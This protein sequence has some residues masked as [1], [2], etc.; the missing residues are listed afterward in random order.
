MEINT[1]RSNKGESFGKLQTRLRV[2][3]SAKAGRNLLKRNRRVD[4]HELRKLTARI[5][6]HDK[7][8]AILEFGK[9]PTFGWA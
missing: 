1:Y 4:L 3:A 6:R 9:Q 7:K 8:I 5:D 2:A